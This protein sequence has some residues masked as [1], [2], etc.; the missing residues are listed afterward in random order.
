MSFQ[1]DTNSRRNKRDLTFKTRF[2]DHSAMMYDICG[3]KVTKYGP[4]RLH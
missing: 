1:L 3:P 4:I 2:V